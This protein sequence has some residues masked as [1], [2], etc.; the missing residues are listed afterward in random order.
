VS[1]EQKIILP[2]FARPKGSQ[3]M[4]DFCVAPPQCTFQV[5]SR[6]RALKSSHFLASKFD[7]D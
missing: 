1:D 6:R 7:S 3:K 5:Q 2:E 4:D